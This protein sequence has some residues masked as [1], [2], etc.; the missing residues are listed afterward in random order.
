[1][2]VLRNADWVDFAAADGYNGDIFNRK[3]AGTM[4]LN[5]FVRI[6]CIAPIT[7]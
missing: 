4:K 5:H 2:L 7:R 3:G 1:M 6:V